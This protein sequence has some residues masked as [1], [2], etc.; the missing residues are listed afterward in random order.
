MAVATDPRSGRGSRDQRGEIALPFANAPYISTH[1]AERRNIGT[2]TPASGNLPGQLPARKQTTMLA[3]VRSSA[4]R[5]LAV[6]ESI[7]AFLL[8][9]FQRPAAR[10]A[11]T[12]TTPCGSKIGSAPLSIPPEVSFQ[13]IPPPARSVRGARALA[14]TKVVV[15]GPLGEVA[16]EVPAYVK[17]DQDPKLPGPTLSVEDS[18]DAVQRAMW[19]MWLLFLSISFTGAAAFA[20]QVIA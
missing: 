12:T 16:M 8:P 18:R 7:P 20:V 3:P 17:I 11:F 15:K 2:S 9:A 6:A 14:N 10:R 4:V 19:G 5:G 13:V 1:R